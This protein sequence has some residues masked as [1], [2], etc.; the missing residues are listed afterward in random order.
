M[1]FLTVPAKYH[2]NERELQM[3]WQ[4]STMQLL[5]TSFLLHTCSRLLVVGDKRKAK[6]HKL[7]KQWGRRK[8]SCFFFR[9]PSMRRLVVMS[10]HAHEQTFCQKLLS[11][12]SLNGTINSHTVHLFIFF[13]LLGF[14]YFLKKI[15][16]K[17]TRR[18]CL[19]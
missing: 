6:P 11:S 18:K 3:N 15:R 12:R 17:S 7:E 5:L 16:S 13:Q 2:F 9:S 10:V 19:K 14:I 8:T 4:N 1:H